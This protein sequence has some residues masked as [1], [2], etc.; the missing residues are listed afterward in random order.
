MHWSRHPSHYLIYA[1]MQR[2]IGA[3]GCY[4]CMACVADGFRPMKLRR[5]TQEAAATCL[6]DL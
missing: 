6:V 1:C 3:T 2:G 5:T 4:M